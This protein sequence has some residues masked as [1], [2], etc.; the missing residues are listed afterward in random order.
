MVSSILERTTRLYT[1]R[2]DPTRQ[3]HAWCERDAEVAI[4]C[5]ECERECPGTNVKGLIMYRYCF[6]RPVPLRFYRWDG[7]YVKLLS[8][9]RD[10]FYFYK[11]GGGLYIAHNFCS[12]LSGPPKVDL[13]DYVVS[14]SDGNIWPVKAERFEKELLE[15]A[16]AWVEL[17][18]GECP[19][20]GQIRD[21]TEMID[22]DGE[23]WEELVRC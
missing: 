6:S 19:G 12:R 1:C 15:R 3:A 18:S 9:F 8:V 16:W 5:H 11:C 10:P 4:G 22:P 20:P 2:H 7:D 14:Y 21:A 13:G 23:L 17:P